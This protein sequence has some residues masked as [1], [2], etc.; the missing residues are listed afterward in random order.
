M[1]A[2]LITEAG[3]LRGNRDLTGD[4]VLHGMVGPAM[5]DKHFIDLEPRR[6]AHELMPEPDPQKRQLCL[7]RTTNG[8]CRAGHSTWIPRT[9]GRED[10]MRI[11]CDHVSHRRTWPQISI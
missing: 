6:N 5:A 10:P 8:L 9:A 2:I 4:E 7:D 1:V 3:N 11:P